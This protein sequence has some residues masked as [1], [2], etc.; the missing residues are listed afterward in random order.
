VYNVKMFNLILMN[1]NTNNGL[2]NIRTHSHLTTLSHDCAIK[3]LSFRLSCCSG[4]FSSLPE[5]SSEREP[6]KN[7]FAIDQDLSLAVERP[8]AL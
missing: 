3:A 6:E 4:F 8:L 5:S 1:N 7:S 2:G